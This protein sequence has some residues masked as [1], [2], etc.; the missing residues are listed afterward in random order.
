M[1]EDKTAE[2]GHGY[3][4]KR[5]DGRRRGGTAENIVNEEGGSVAE[6]RGT[7]VLWVKKY[8]IIGYRWN[9]NRTVGSEVDIFY[10]FKW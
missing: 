5:R 9:P 3:E 4:R 8:R 7:K 1:A 2:E 6:R 10:F